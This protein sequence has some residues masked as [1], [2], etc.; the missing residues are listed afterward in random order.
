MEAHYMPYIAV[1]GAATSPPKK[2]I[3]RAAEHRGYGVSQPL[4]SVRVTNYQ[5][6]RHQRAQE[7][8]M[9]DVRVTF[10]AGP[11]RFTHSV[12]LKS[13]QS[14]RTRMTIGERQILLPIGSYIV[15]ETEVDLTDEHERERVA[16]K[17]GEVVKPYNS[18]VLTPSG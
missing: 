14:G 10:T 3:A 4:V 2:P 17:I 6:P 15:I 11:L 8:H 12:P 7:A 9:S 5:T 13:F 18:E 1:F 16:L